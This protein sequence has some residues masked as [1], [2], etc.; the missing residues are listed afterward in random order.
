MPRSAIHHV[1]VD[2]VVPLHAISPLLVRVVS[3]APPEG[4][5]IV[6]ERMNIEMK[7]VNGE[8]AIDAGIEQLG[9][10]SPYACP[11]CHG[12]LLQVEEGKR[13]RFR[14]HTGHAYSADS[15]LAAINEGIEEALWNTVRAIDEGARY[16][17]H[18]ADHLQQQDQASADRFVQEALQARRQ[19]E[20]VRQV[21]T[22]R[23]ALK[24]GDFAWTVQR[25]A[26]RQP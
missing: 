15:L 20:A 26:S 14:C 23:E 4:G 25:S 21:V 17:R 13:I 11:E 12:V 6:S 22:G 18:L 1:K 16:I 2:H 10:P 3:T 19:S 5:A 24:G 7:I 9:P 8:N